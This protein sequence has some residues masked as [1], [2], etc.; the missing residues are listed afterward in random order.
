MKAV[1]FSLVAIAALAGCAEPKHEQEPAAPPAAPVKQASAT[2]L[3]PLEAKKFGEPITEKAETALNDVIKAPGR[4][5][6]K[7]IR[8]QGVVS[9]VCQAKGCWME[10]QDESGIAHIR[11]AGHAFGVPRNASGHRAVVQAKVIANEKDHCTEEAEE[12]TGKQATIQL[13]ATGV[14]F[15]D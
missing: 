3:T 13:E 4:F 10:L 14:E 9:A 12:Q 7:T 2:T 5:A 11:M 15:I 1:V 8:T 6:Q